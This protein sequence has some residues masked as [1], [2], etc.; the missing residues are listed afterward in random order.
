MLD[1][2]MIRENGQL[3]KEKLLS[4]NVDA[5]IE[6]LLELDARWRKVNQEADELKHHRNR[7]SEEINR[8]KKAKEEAS[9]MI[10]SMREV[11]AKIKLLDSEISELSQSIQN[12]L[13]FFPN[14]PA[15]S[16]PVGNSEADNLEIRRS[17]ETLP[18]FDFPLKNHLELG[19]ALGLFDFG[20]GAKISGSNFPLYLGRGAKL[21]RSLINFMLD[22]H[23]GEHGY[24]EVFPPFLS[25]RASTTATGQLPKLADDMYYVSGDELYLI[26]TAE[27]PVT[28]IHRE[29][30]LSLE[31]IPTKYAAFSACF[32]REAGSYG[33]DT[34]GLQ[35]LHQFN[36]VE[37][38][39]FAH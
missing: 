27:V 10:L 17:C 30:I 26:P 5:D 20:R 38:V 39:H 16:T 19:E 12:K 37:L 4:K 32:R 3:V 14:I 22:L 11:G 24:T 8:R 7:V 29:E 9:E 31:Q 13:L 15:E 21:E 2:R 34:R 35:R 1:I 23:T 25:N 6:G 18:D 33:K 36:K 28:N